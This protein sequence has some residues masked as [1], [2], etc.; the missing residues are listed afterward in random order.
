MTTTLVVKGTKNAGKYHH[1]LYVERR[2]LH[3]GYFGPG[4]LRLVGTNWSLMISD[5]RLD[6]W[7]R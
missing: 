2:Q 1:V 5:G 3:C 7:R 4:A 6:A